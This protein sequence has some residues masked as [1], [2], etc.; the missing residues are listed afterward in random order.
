MVLA[1]DVLT[2]EY[3]SDALG[4]RQSVAQIARDNGFTEQTVRA[5]VHRF[6][7]PVPIPSAARVQGQG[8]GWPEHRPH[9]AGRAM[10]AGLDGL[11]DRRRGRPQQDHRVSVADPVRAVDP[12]AAQPARQ[13]PQD[14]LVRLIEAGLSERELR[15]PFGCAQR[16]IQ[17]R[18][19]R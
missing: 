13:A 10:R 1:Q 18:L 8:H 19:S 2:D 16:T 14:E 6:G 11:A 9:Q 5:Y 12:M 17:R 15:E 7:I 3:L 4:R